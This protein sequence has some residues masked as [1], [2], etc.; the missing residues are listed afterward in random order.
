MKITY[1]QINGNRF[2]INNSYVNFYTSF[3]LRKKYS[4]VS[5]KSSQTPCI[6]FPIHTIHIAMKYLVLLF[7][8]YN[9]AGP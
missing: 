3:D 8:F 4:N 6:L 7:V 5:G 2:F 1:R 9:Y